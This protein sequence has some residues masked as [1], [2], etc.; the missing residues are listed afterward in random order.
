MTTTLDIPNEVLERAMKLT[1]A[2]TQEEAVLA[3]VKGFVEQNS[4]EYAVSRL[5]TFEKFMTQEELKARREQ[6]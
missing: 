2:R 5:G 4:L 3:A 1:H 6:L